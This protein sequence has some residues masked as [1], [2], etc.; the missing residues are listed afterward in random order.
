VK[1]QD[2]VTL[3]DPAIGL[4]AITVGD[5]LLANLVHHNQ[6]LGE[7]VCLCSLQRHLGIS[8]TL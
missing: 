4:G 8:Q 7:I 5:S 2:F 6:H 3:V 1:D